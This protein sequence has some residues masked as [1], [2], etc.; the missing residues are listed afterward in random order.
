MACMPRDYPH[1]CC[2]C[3]FVFPD[4]FFFI[5]LTYSNKTSIYLKY[6]SLSFAFAVYRYTCTL[7][8]RSIVVGVLM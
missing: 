4:V 6:I 3:F 1:L 8:V 7:Y 5:K 2:R